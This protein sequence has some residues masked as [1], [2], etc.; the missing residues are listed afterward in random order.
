MA[1]SVRAGPDSGYSGAED[2]LLQV[3]LGMK[4]S[5]ADQQEL[6]YR[7]LQQIGHRANCLEKRRKKKHE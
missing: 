2:F 6:E 7:V 3:Y 4:N 5:T 1:E